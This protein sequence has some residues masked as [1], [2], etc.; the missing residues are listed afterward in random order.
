VS[1]ESPATE[2]ASATHIEQLI[3]EHRISSSSSVST[4]HLTP[5]SGGSSSGL[6]G[7]PRLPSLRLGTL[8]SISIDPGTPTVPR[9]DEAE[10]TEYHPEE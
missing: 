1:L 4:K 6:G 5:D 3:S 2:S 7:I 9:I 10:E 8:P